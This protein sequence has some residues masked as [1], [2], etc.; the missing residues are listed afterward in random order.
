MSDSEGD[1]S[2]PSRPNPVRIPD[3]IVDRMGGEKTIKDIKDN[4]DG[5][6]DISWD[7]ITGDTYVPVPGGGWQPTG[8]NVFDLIEQQEKQKNKWKPGE[9]K[10]RGNRDCQERSLPET[11]APPPV[12]PAVPKPSPA[13]KPAPGWFPGFSFPLL[14]I[15]P[16]IPATYDRNGNQTI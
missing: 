11:V 8:D 14:P 9:S 4:T 13:P 7:P 15:I 3:H 2:Q 12:V 5:N 16:Y 10:P 6:P 1:Y